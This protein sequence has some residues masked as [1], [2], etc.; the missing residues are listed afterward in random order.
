MVVSWLSK[1][2]RIDQS[3]GSYFCP[4]PLLEGCGL[5]TIRFT[6]LCSLSQKVSMHPPAKILYETLL[7]SMFILPCTVLEFMLNRTATVNV[8]LP[9]LEA[10]R[11]DW[12][13]FQ[14]SCNYQLV[15]GV[16]Q[17]ATLLKEPHSP[18]VY[19]YILRC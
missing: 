14:P 2:T 13:H 9:K 16:F 8:F 18:K 6:H 19:F 11:Q 15:H 10:F 7:L 5:H 17:H 3:Q 12:P 4:Q 1:H